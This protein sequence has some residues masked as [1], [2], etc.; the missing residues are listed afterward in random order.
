MLQELT[1]RQ[2]NTTFPE[3]ADVKRFFQLF[4]M[5]WAIY[6]FAKAAFYYWLGSIMPLTEAIA[7][8]SIVGGV[9]LALM[10]FLSTTQ[11]R[12]LLALCRRVGL[13]PVAPDRKTDA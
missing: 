3:G 9:S 5:L 8:R 13:L 2:Q 12:R 1:E 11:G 6:I 7:L 4:A 10:I